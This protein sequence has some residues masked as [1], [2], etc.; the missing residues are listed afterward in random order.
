MSRAAQ[1]A[2]CCVLALPAAASQGAAW[3][4][5]HFACWICSQQALLR[6]HT[7]S[8]VFNY[9]HRFPVVLAPCSMGGL[10]VKDL[11]V[12]A[13]AQK[14]ERLRRWGIEC[15]HPDVGAGSLA[16]SYLLAG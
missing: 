15:E 8:A 16:A 12:S 6:A 5:C 13:K 1:R 11:L 9:L 10:V 14:D 7:T 2:V 4:A 3:L